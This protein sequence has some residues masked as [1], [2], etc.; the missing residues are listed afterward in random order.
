M[1]VT[2]RSDGVIGLEG[3]CGADDA[4]ALQRAFLNAPGTSVE[5]TQCTVLHAAVLQVLLAAGRP[6]LGAPANAFLRA[7]VARL[8]HAA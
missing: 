2:V 7:H 5:W 1:T 3:D 4:E 6:V 8:V